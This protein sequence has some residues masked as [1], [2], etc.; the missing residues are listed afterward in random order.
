MTEKRP[1]TT[2]QKTTEFLCKPTP[3]KVFPEFKHKKLI[4]YNEKF[5][6]TIKPYFSNKGLNIRNIDYFLKKRISAKLGIS[7]MKKLKKTFSFSN[8]LYF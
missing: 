6:K 3:Q 7:E 8:H 5:C 4:G 2:G 1:M